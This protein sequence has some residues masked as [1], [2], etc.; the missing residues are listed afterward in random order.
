[1]FFLAAVRLILSD[2]R[3]GSADRFGIEAA[4]SGV[5]SR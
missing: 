5:V 4:A 1:M 2:N 3:G